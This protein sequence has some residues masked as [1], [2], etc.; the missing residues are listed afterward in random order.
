MPAFEP[1]DAEAL[2]ET[3]RRLASVRNLGEV[4][5]VVCD[6]VRTLTGADGASFVVRDN[7]TVSYLVD[8]AIGTSRPC[9]PIDD[10]I[11][12]WVML[13]RE[14]V[15]IS[16]VDADDRP[17]LYRGTFVKS[18]VMAPVRIDDPVAAI[19]AY[20]A[21][22]G[23]VSSR[24]VAVVEAI[25]TLA[26]VAVEYRLSLLADLEVRRQAEQASR[27]K[28]E[29]LALLGHELRNPL[30]PIVTTLHLIKLRGGD[31]FERERSVIDRQVNNLVRIVDDLLDVSRIT[32]GAIR[33]RRV[34][35]ELGWIVARGLE[36]ARPRLEERGHNVEVIVP[37]TGLMI[38]ADIDRLTQVVTNLLSNAA[39]YTPRG[40]RIEV[41]GGI[42]GGCARLV[43]RD[44][45][46][47]IE[48]SL[49]PRLFDLFQSERPSDRFEGGL[50][51][52]LA[53]VRSMV[54]L[55]GGVV[56]AAS[57]G[58]GR[59]ATFTI[60]LPLADS[61][62]PEAPLDEPTEAQTPTRPLRV[63]VVDDNVDAAETLGALLTLM[64]HEPV[65][66]YDGP[67]ALRRVETFT[68][69]LSFLDIGLPEL[70][71]YELAE[72]MRSVP[73]LSNAPLVA[74]TAFG[75]DADKQRARAA[76]FDA[77]LVKP[78]SAEK[79]KAVIEKL[80]S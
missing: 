38:E 12:G 34:P 50:G 16:N 8:D 26:V 4:G 15:A 77:H 68:P 11:A 56:S 53:I 3:A 45:G 55:H 17:E 66:V 20:W 70:D 40:G 10:C 48:P 30:A 22:V 21:R 39:K 80:T 64:G 13:H 58:P 7:A 60:R 42:E 62:E 44:T 32:R 63:L 57:A 1:G 25:A 27:A 52:G 31:P 23:A 69:E 67:Q 18:L 24:A 33:L 9:V 54:E 5:T 49:L 43:V 61:A 76:G 6:V 37:E 79:L 59:G 78:L 41:L 14:T 29:F 71:G 2:L 46:T 36:A 72:R 73:R 28:D 65:V 75:R 47:G 51:F 35:I 74:L 19:G